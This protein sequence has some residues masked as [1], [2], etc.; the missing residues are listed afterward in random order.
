M[1]R[2]TCLQPNLS[3]VK[4]TTICLLILCA[5]NQSAKAQIGFL[6]H[7]TLTDTARKEQITDSLSEYKNNSFLIRHASTYS[8]GTSLYKN[9]LFLS[10][11]ALHNQYNTTLPYGDNDDNM[12]PAVGFQTRVSVAFT[13][14]F[15]N[16]VIKLAPDFI[17]A[18]NKPL[19]TF[20]RDMGD[21]LYY[22]R[23]YLQQVNRLDAFTRFGVQSITK[24]LPGQSS[25]QYQFKNSAIA[26]STESLW[27]GAGIRN[28]LV[29]TNNAPGFLHI[30]YQSIQPVKTKFGF[31]EWQAILGR[32]NNASVESPYNDTMRT[33]WADGI[34]KK[35]RSERMIAGFV[36]SWQPKWTRGLYIGW[37]NTTTWYANHESRPADPLGLLSNRRKPILL[38]AFFL[39]YTM[40]K[41]NAE[42]YAEFGRNNKW[43]TPW[44]LLQDTIPTGYVIGVRKMIPLNR[45]KG[46]IELNVE[47][48]RLQLQHANL[49]F[50]DVNPFAG[51]KA[52]S[53]YTSD[54]VAQGYSN[55]AQILG[56][57]IGPGSNSQTLVMSWNKTA[58]RIGMQLERVV[59][60]NDFYYYNYFTGLPGD[61][62]NNRY[63]TDIS[64]GVFGQVRISKWL[65]ACSINRLSAL[66]YRWVKTT[67]GWDTDPTNDRK[68]W[69]LNMSL[70]YYLH[71]MLTK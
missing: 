1:E 49:I 8:R 21:P 66:N 32:L 58:M 13:Y 4:Y 41:D 47:M 40:P 45:N 7:I 48:S 60:N 2:A 50:D 22:P 25:I 20:N 65:V 27:W 62:T 54:Y 55:N 53:W 37:A 9:G 26:I 10:D 29:L 28:S 68:N 18:E 6:Q 16:V 57:A 24:F 15:D 34:A 35:N 38:G 44:N 17:F 61:G 67:R 36:V 59:R 23:Y 30:G 31:I 69:Q 42:I 46:F 11:I 14:K 5:I 19:P 64:W 71:Q 33:I 43:A 56:A 63:W 51:P 3:M 12:F 52:N 39:R 70:R